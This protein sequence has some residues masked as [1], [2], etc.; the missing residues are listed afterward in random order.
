MSEHPGP[1]PSAEQASRAVRAVV[2]RLRRRLL[3][4]SAAQDV[5]LSQAAVLARLS[6]ATGVTASELAAAEGVRHQSMTATVTSLA[7]RDLVRRTPD[8][9]DGR[10]L[11]LSLTAEGERRVAEARQAR[12]EWLAV[13][14]QDRCT[15]EERQT[16]LAAMSVLERLTHD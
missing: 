13:R 1:S 6:G 7:A 4:A 15:E 10:R 11:L 9:Q 3:K 16:V 2:S 14:L 12:T 8:P 5:T